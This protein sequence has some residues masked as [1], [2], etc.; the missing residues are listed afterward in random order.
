VTT[1][2]IT[3]HELLACAIPDRGPTDPSPFRLTLTA[4]GQFPASGSDVQRDLG[5]HATGRALSFNPATIGVDAVANDSA[6]ATEGG[7]IGHSER[8]HDDRI[9][10]SLWP[11]QTACEVVSADGGYPGT[12]AGQALGFSAK[13][14][15][16]LVAGENAGDQRAGSSLVFAT[17]TGEA[18]IVPRERGTLRVSRA[19]AT[20]TEFGDGLLVAGGTNPATNAAPEDAAGTAEVFDPAT[21]GFEPTLVELWSRRTHHAAVTLATTGETLLVGGLAPDAAGSGPGQLIRQ[22]EAVSPS[23]RTSS[24]S[25]LLALDLG[26]VDPTALVLTNGRIL[27]GGGYAAGGDAN[28]PRGAPIGQIEGFSADATSRVFRA[29]LPPRE[30]R[31]FAALPGGGALSVASCRNDP[32]RG[33]E[34]SCFT[35][36][37]AP[38]Q[39]TDGNQAWL[40]AWWIDPNGTATAV[41]FEPDGVVAPCATVDTPLLA[42]GSDGAPWLTFPRADGTPACV[43]RF[44]AWPAASDPSDPASRPRFVMTTFA[45]DPSPDARSALLGFG[46][47]AF[48][49]IGANGGL[50]GGRFGQRG[51]LTRDFSLLLSSFDAPFRPAHLMPDRDATRPTSSAD[52][53]PVA[54]ERTGSRLTLTPVEPS[55]TVWVTDTLYDG[56]AISLGVEPTSDGSVPAL[57]VLVFQSPKGATGTCAWNTPPAAGASAVVTVT[58]SRNGGHATLSAPN[59][60]DATCDVP[61]GSLAIGIRADSAAVTLT[62]LELSRLLLE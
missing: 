33:D 4:L 31:T 40:D 20:V 47:D 5:L 61:P 26:R 14:G 27:V 38:C 11:E 10:V 9:D 53:P 58:A 48:M 45:L 21:A 54:F 7:F 17:D 62:E 23:T 29:E 51:P 56:V 50:F 55:V 35:A 19:F 22:F 57:P 18:S 1:V 52:A 59:V 25:G 34:C 16:S 8:R 24:I 42:A 36:D 39:P 49:W 60:A 32:S 44:E 28:A 43:W 30:N 6:G 15:L 2:S 41:T 3:A 46:P 12:G 37:G 13:S